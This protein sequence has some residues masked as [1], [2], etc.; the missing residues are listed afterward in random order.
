MEISVVIPCF[1]AANTLPR[2]LRSLSQQSIAPKQYE[3]FLVDDGSTDPSCEIA[4]QFD[5][6]ILLKQNRMGPGAARNLGADQAKGRIILFLDSDLDVAPDLLEKHVQAY[7]D[8]PG[9]A[10]AGGSVRPLGEPALC[11]WQLVDHLSSWFNAHPSVNNTKPP[12]YLPSLNFSVDREKVWITHQLRWDPGLTHTGED[13]L[14]CHAL[15][16]ANLSLAFVPTAVVFHQD[17][18]TLRGYMTHMYR[19]GF[20]AP[21]VR[22]KIRGLKYSFLFPKEPWKQILFLPAIVGGYTLLVWRAWLSER[23]LQATLGLP[24]LLLGRLAYAQG[25][26]QGCLARAREART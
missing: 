17:R 4:G 10:A 23:P 8:Q 11:S 9:L 6:V 1:N 26:M 14:F 3:I 16:Q 22:G 2:L 15:K 20:H 12:E 5:R 13:V 21:F 25:V 18:T 7:R 24:Q 19:W